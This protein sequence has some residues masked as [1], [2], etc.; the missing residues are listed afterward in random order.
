MPIE[1][2]LQLSPIIRSPKIKKGIT[3]GQASFRQ[4]TSLSMNKTFNT[5]LQLGTVLLYKPKCVQVLPL[6]HRASGKDRQ[7][8]TDGNILFIILSTRK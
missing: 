7:Q 6:Q 1:H 4:A 2:N 8:K 3:R 5:E